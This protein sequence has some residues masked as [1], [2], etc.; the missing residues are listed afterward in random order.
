MSLTFLST[1]ERSVTTVVLTFLSSLMYSK[2]S[3]RRPLE[4]ITAPETTGPSFNDSVL[5]S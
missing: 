4:V 5:K 1:P 3:V 2:F